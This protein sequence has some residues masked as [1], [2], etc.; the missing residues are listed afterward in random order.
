[1]YFES[2]ENT[3]NSFIIF[4]FFFCDIFLSLPS[5]RVA[6]YSYILSSFCHLNQF[7]CLFSPLT[8][9]LSDHSPT[10]LPLRQRHHF[11]PQLLPSL[12]LPS[13]M[14]VFHSCIIITFL[15]LNMLFCPRSLP[16]IS[17]IL[18]HSV[19]PIITTLLPSSLWHV[20][21]NIFFLAQFI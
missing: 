20:S 13:I 12:N 5:L 9:V 10:F 3:G 7:F 2:D 16:I 8:S 17:D 1:M 21:N 11:L 19:T 15:H 4:I 18:P 6:L 14:P